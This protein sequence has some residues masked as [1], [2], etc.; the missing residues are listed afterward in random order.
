MYTFLLNILV[1]A[2]VIAVMVSIVAI[3][4]NIK[5]KRWHSQG[6]LLLDQWT[7]AKNRRLE[8]L[9]EHSYLPDHFQDEAYQELWLSELGAEELMNIFTESN[10]KVSREQYE[11][12]KAQQV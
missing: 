12:E 3:V 5:E 7:E 11:R 6:L 1:S 2:S 8:W 10:G 4:I 9:K